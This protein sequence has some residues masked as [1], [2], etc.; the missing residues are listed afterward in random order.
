MEWE[1]KRMEI[2]EE[3]EYFGRIINENGKIDR[4]INN[5]M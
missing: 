3:I 4:D 1:G 5:S 2:V